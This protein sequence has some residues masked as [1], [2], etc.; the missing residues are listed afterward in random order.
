MMRPGVPIRTSTP[1]CERAALL[2]VVD[3]AECEAEREAGVLRE[4]LGVAVDLDRELARRREHQRARRGGRP[5]RGCRVAQQVREEGDQ[6]RGGLAGAGLGLSRDVEARERP[7]QRLGLDR[8]AVLEARVG[9]AAGDGF[10]QVQ[11]GEGKVRELLMCQ[12]ITTLGV[13]T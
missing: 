3:A 10:R 7:R 9:D 13:I 11:S 1:A 2:V 8:R 5:V 12:R 4:H 6:E